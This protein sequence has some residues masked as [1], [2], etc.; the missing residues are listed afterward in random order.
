MLIKQNNNKTMDKYHILIKRANM[1]K[2]YLLLGYNKF[3]F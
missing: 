3:I 1:K 2:F